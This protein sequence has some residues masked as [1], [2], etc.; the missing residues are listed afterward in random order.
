MT[1]DAVEYL[2][3]NTDIT[4]LEQ[5]SIARGLVD[6]S[7]LE[8]ARLQDFVATNFDNSFL[9]TAKGPFL[10]LFGEALGTP[11]KLE[12]KARIFKEDGAIRFYVRNGTLGQRL[13]DPNDPTKGRIPSGT[14]VSSASGDIQYSVSEDTTFPLNRRSVFVGATSV[15]KGTGPNVGPNQL[16]VHSLSDSTVFVINDIA[17]TT[18]Q[19]LESDEDYRFRLTRAFS[20][21]FSSNS[22]AVN[23]AATSIAGVVQANLVP[24]ARGAGTFDVLVVPRGNRLPKSV[25]DQAL[26][27]IELVS[28]YG[29]SPAVREPVYVPVRVSV[30]LRFLQGT[31]EGLKDAIRDNAQFAILNYIGNI[32]LG[33]E[34]VINQLRSSILSSSENLV[35]LTLLELCIDGKPNAIRNFKLE[36]DELFT[37]DD[38]NEAVIVL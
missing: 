2:S 23:V 29:I 36:R 21:R 26:S 38:R 8:I 25:R 22:A 31:S 19:D 14:L 20:T 24:F 3:E 4:F 5:G 32:P 28:A 18:G 9:S 7:M 13:P 12:T 37:P 16:V 17:I 33:G 27:A 35:D 34:L 1:S 11:R 6:A 30:R 10:D 15:I